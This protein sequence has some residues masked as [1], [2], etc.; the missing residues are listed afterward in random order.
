MQAV[1]EE[2]EA[3]PLVAEPLLV[4]DALLDGLPLDGLPQAARTA[5]AAKV[6]PT[7]ARGR[8]YRRREVLGSANLLPF[9]GAHFHEDRS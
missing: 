1:N 2:L 4:A 5:A 7:A 3:A 8:P 9:T 6:A